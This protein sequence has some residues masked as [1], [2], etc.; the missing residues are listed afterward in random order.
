MIRKAAAVLLVS[1]ACA[2]AHAAQVYKWVDEQGHVHYGNAVPKPHQKSAQ[3]VDTTVPVPSDAER[4]DAAALAEREKAAAENLRRER[5]RARLQEASKAAPA[6]K[7]APAPAVKAA[8]APVPSTAPAP[9]PSSPT[10]A[11]SD[12]K[13]QCEEEFKRF[14]QSQDCFAPYRTATG[15]IRAEAFKHCVEVKMPAFCE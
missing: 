11:L 9:A 7:A 2:F 10:T 14:R 15:G 4:R 8:P 13:R 6:G 1:S 3:P 12:K 5:E